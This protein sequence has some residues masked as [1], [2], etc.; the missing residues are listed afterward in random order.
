MRGWQLSADTGGT[1]TDCLLERPDGSLKRNK[2]LSSGRLRT[3][4]GSASGPVLRVE[5]VV[6]AGSLSLNG[7]EIR[8]A[9]RVMGRLR[10]WT[11][12]RMELEPGHEPVRPGDILE[13]DSGL[14]APVLAMRSLLHGEPSPEG[15]EALSLRL[16]TTKGTNALLE[17]KGAPTALFLTAGFEDLLR[18]RDQK[19]PEL[20]ARKI[21]R[22]DPLYQTVYGLRG[23]MDTDG[24]ATEPLDPAEVERLGRQALAEGCAAAAVCLLNS[25]RNPAHEEEV[26]AILAACGFRTVIRS[27]AV[28][29]L[30]KYLDRAE[31]TLVDATLS[32][33]MD[34]Y[35]DRV[36]AGLKG[37]PLWIMSS[38][39]GLLSRQRFHAVDSLVSGPAGGV[40]GAVAAAR[41]AGLQAIIAL[42][43]GGTSTDVSR[44]NERLELRQQI[45][46]GAARILTP[47]MP[48]ETVAAG[49]GSICGFDGRRLHVGPD[50]AGAD[51]GPAA[52]GAGGPLTLTD[53]HLLLGRMDPA[54]FSIPIRIEEARK[55]V[56]R[57]AEAAGESDWQR[58]AEGFLAIATERMSQAI[59]QVSLREGADPSGYALVAF[60]GAGGLHACRLADELGMREVLF[61]P[62]AGIL[63]ARG[64]HTAPREV[65]L[66][67]QVLVPLE[68][69]GER[70]A[71]GFDALEA[72]ARRQLAADGVVPGRLDAPIRTAFVRIAG[73]ETSLPVPVAAGG[74]PAPGF[75]EQFVTIFGYYPAEARLELVKLR[76]RLRERTAG[77]PRERFP[78]DGPPARQSGTVAGICEGR[79]GEIPVYDREGLSPGAGLAGPAIIR[80]RFGTAF[81]EPGWTARAGDRG[82]VRLA[83][84][85]SGASPVRTVA[86]RTEQVL[87]TLILN[88]LEGLVE[89]MG[90]QL[91]RTALSANIRERLDFSCALLDAEGRLLVNAP[92]IP[93]HL[94][95]LGLCVRECIRDHELGPG[96]VL[97]TNHPG[98]GGS[99]L[100]DVTLV[101]RL[102]TAGGEPMGYLASRAHHAEWG[103]SSPGSMPAHA[104]SLEEEGVILR[105][106]WLIRDGRDRFEAI[107]GQLRTARYPSRAVRENRID[108]EA[109][110]AS[111]RRGTG[112]FAD[113][114]GEFSPDR[115]GDCFRELY[116]SG[117]EALSGALETAGFRSGRAEVRMDD[118]QCIKVSITSEN[119]A[120]TVDFSGTDPVHPGNL[121][122]TPAIVR[123][124]VL[125]VMRFLVD[126]PMPLNEGLLHRVR[127]VLPRCF[128]NPAFPDDPAAC[129][130]VVGGNVETSQAVVEA[131]IEALGLQAASQGTMN[132][133][134]FGNERFGCYETIGGGSGAGE[135]FDGA[136]GVHVHMTN[137]AITD[138]EVLEQRFPVECREFSLRRESGGSGRFRG[139]DGLCREIRFREAVTVSFLGQRRGAGPRGAAGGGDGLTGRQ[140]IR[141]TDGSLEPIGGMAEAALRPGEAIRIETPG[142]GGWGP[143]ARL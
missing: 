34:A 111:L 47:A 103:G 125:Y 12:E 7:R 16:G 136:S 50:S 123:S 106:Q 17:N 40:L 66:E 46:V 14:E 31:T 114:L 43:M 35:L 105:P 129:P 83:R 63:S 13:V 127:I 73:Q 84:G 140:F 74:D 59:R 131:L 115:V 64:I 81:V 92:H 42:D 108:L 110:L 137:T 32:P 5:A 119:G 99:H 134:L 15:G 19:R 60:G 87:K 142:G 104:T 11:G 122:A 58:L 4:V 29:P 126:R 6:V 49:G 25:W 85:S 56:A 37:N 30:I 135:G 132:N 97:V 38:S 52:Y 141:G 68:G 2:V 8:R 79:S 124:A 48:I 33:V 27:S 3:R 94:G 95:A 113:L 89:E 20:F 102:F 72:S 88:R 22:P 130:A 121:N 86:P 21:E 143:D 24:Q 118:G 9:G 53:I 96:D 62:D 91:Q 65:V 138:P 45:R 117:T 77:V 41:Q 1:F 26:A 28:R 80:D 54:G 82:S 51:P 10:H 101:S 23:R 76:L 75:H 120:A 61:P 70:M 109:Q 116:T 133:L 44:W 67:E 55:A 107:T 78:E 112:L 39:G 57:V 98:F 90:D 139:G 18:I 100:P 69:S 71:S 36:E 93:V 128:L